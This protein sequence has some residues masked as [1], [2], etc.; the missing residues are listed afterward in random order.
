MSDYN[1]LTSL[2]NA[3]PTL[4]EAYA[5]IC[6]YVLKNRLEVPK[7]STEELAQACG[8][9]EATVVRFA[10]KMGLNGYRDFKISLSAANVLQTRDGI[11][12]ADVHVSDTT[13]EVLDK[14][15]SFTVNSLE[16][17]A[18]V[19]DRNELNSAI[20]LIRK[21][22]SKGGRIFVTGFGSSSTVAQAFVIKMMRLGVSTVYYSDIHV[23]LESLLSISPSDILVCFSVLGRTVENDQIVTIARDHGSEVIVITQQGNSLIAQKATCLL[24]TACVENNL[25]LASQTALIVQLL[26]VDVIFTSLALENLDSTR[27]AV[28]ESRKAFYELGHYSTCPH[29]HALQ[30]MEGIEY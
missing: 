18:A 19:L 11:E 30:D 24:L 26:L 1:L 6:S 22:S 12:L 29:P 14:L 15:T 4:T 21:V 13:G 7:M 10:R 27:A 16:N 23:Q 9:S 5:S 20:E 25:R 17:T 2:S 28:E 8:V 3:L